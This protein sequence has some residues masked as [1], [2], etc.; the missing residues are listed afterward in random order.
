MLDTGIHAK[1]WT[2]EQ[3]SEYA[4]RN[5]AES[6]TMIR[7]EVE[8]F[9]AIPAQGLAYKIGQLKIAE[10]RQR[11]EQK[12]GSRFD[13]KAFHRAVLEDGALPLDVL[14]AEIDRWIAT[15]ATRSS[16]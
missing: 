7:S 4:R 12:L 14:D 15:R 5:S 8:R 6:E 16:P 11:A 1:G 3:A 10:L 2:L 13:I 9:S